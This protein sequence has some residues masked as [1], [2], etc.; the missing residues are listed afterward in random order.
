MSNDF[1]TLQAES[2]SEVEF[3]I[4]YS[5]DEHGAMIPHSPAVDYHPDREDPTI[6]GYAR[7]ATAVNRIKEEKNADSEPVL[8]FSG[9]DFIGGTAFSWL[10]PENYAPE[11]S[12]KQK[13]GYDAV[14]IGNHE[15]DYGADVLADYLGEAGYP[16]AHS[17][18]AVLVSNVNV[19]SEHPLADKN[20]YRENHI[21]TLENG[22]KI[23]LFG[24]MGK[25]AVEIATE[26]APL[27]FT[28]QH[29]AAR[30][31]VGDLKTQGA[32][33]IVALAHSG[34]GEDRQLAEAVPGI[35]LIIGGHCH[36]ALQE[37]IIENDTIIVQAGAYLEY[38]GRLDLAYDLAA[39]SVQ[40][41]NK[42]NEIPLLY[43]LDS[44]YTVDPDIDQA[45]GVYKE[46]LNN[47]VTERTDGQFRHILDPVVI[48]DFKI[49][50]YPPLQ[51]TPFG[52]FV[53][54]AMRLVAKEKT[55]HDPDFAV[56]A[57]G[58]IRGSVVP[59]SMPHSLGQV[60][61]YDLTELV[62]LGYGPDGKAGYPLVA[63]YLT[64]EEILRVLEVAAL[65]EEVMDNTYFLQF[66]GLRY[67]Y[68]PENAVLFNVPILDL[69]LPTARAVLNAERYT[70]EG[71]QG[72]DDREYALIEKGEQ[73]LYCLITDSLV[74][75]F[76]PMIGELLPQ[77]EITLKDREGNP[78]S[79]EELEKQILYVNGEELKVWQ[80]VVEYAA[81]QPEG[82]TGFP[83]VESYYASTAGR[84]NP[85]R[86]I[87]YLALLIL[88]LII[89]LVV[90]V[91]GIRR[92][93]LN[94]KPSR[95]SQP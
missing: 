44:S 18:T 35:D 26:Y 45:V 2:E 30:K 11:L 84:I 81:N 46:K 54:D 62:G 43:R 66:S 9:G 71:R 86:S 55:D 85:V 70:K 32:Q 29:E 21:I 20:L 58:A 53:T 3:T 80:A 48:S 13:I 75:S 63:V 36:T 22:L 27:E 1:F 94:R 57:N 64:G 87:P 59:G 82:E 10:V 78:L 12:V 68:N 7:L 8:L 14:V 4:L 72:I 60:S 25:D 61:F 92:R 28:D 42:E 15:F 93:R 33:V 19:P 39:D 41:R 76:F 88:A 90:A 56:Q 16:D 73:E 34:V 37:P 89:I 69:P 67:Q 52:N 17:D 50:D 65:I 74:V 47:L 83:E 38:L 6:G 23:G 95:K 51:E 24:L 79:E 91:L 5:N 31:M 49:P 40:I 77:L